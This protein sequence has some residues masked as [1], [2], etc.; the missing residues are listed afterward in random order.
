M[1]LVLS[2][3]IK[4]C[5]IFIVFINIYFIIE[6]YSDHG[7]VVSILP[8]YNHKIIQCGNGEQRDC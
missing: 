4:H 7:K 1:R 8:V 5:S 3:L 6:W 2:G